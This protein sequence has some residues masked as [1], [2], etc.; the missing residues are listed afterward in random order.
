M[1][2]DAKGTSAKKARFDLGNYMIS[3]HG[4]T[5]HTVA[6][7]DLAPPSPRNGYSVVAEYWKRRVAHAPLKSGYQCF[8]ARSGKRNKQPIL[9]TSRQKSIDEDAEPEMA[10]S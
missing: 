2:V 4:L 5:D 1:L 6:S 7:A 9:D 10:C 8:H 3:C